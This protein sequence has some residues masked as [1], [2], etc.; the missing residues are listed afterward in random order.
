MATGRKFAGKKLPLT[1]AFA[2]L[3]VAAFGA[4]CKGFFVPP[5][6]TSIT[7][8]PTAP[9]VQLDQ[10]A[11]V[12]AYG[13][14]SINQGMYLTSGVSWSSSDDTIVTVTGSG[15]GTLTGVATGTATITAASESVTNTATATVYITV[16]TLSITPTSQTITGLGGVTP[17]P[18]IVKANGSIDI[19][20]SA[21]LNVLLNGTQVTTVN[22]SYETSGASGGGPG[23][24]CTG[25]GTEVAGQYSVVA[26][27]TNT[28][29]TATATLNINGT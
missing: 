2:V 15:S 20:S 28:T 12:Q 29:V 7:I 24:Y 17:Q 26:S 10:T 8:N 23:Q 1:I 6:L 11:I 16:S 14:N 13:V 27:Y 3:L 5:T 21:T 19:S 22:C 18:Y 9:S 25:D 4:G